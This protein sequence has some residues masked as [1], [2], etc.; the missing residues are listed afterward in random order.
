[1]HNIPKQHVITLLYL[2]E[3]PVTQ[4]HLTMMAPMLGCHDTP[5]SLRSRMVELERE[6]YTHRVDRDGV[7]TRHR[8][9]WRWQLTRKGKNLARDLA[10]GLLD[11]DTQDERKQERP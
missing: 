8:P 10:Q 11:T 2:I 6:G 9:C 7:S 1:M 4:E 5:Q 3:D